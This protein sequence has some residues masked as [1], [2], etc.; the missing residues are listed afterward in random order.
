MLARLREHGPGPVVVLNPGGSGMVKWWPHAQEAMRLFAAAGVYTVLLG[1][2][3][4]D[5]LEPVEPYAHVVGMEWPVRHALTFAQLA[6]AVVG[7]E[8]LIVNAV[9]MEPMLKVV[10]LSHSSN[11]NLTKHWVNTAG[12]EPKAVGCH[13]CHRVHPQTF[14]FCSQDKTTGFAACQA[15]VGPQMIVDFVINYLRKAG[16]LGAEV[17]RLADRWP[18]KEA[19]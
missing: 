1:R 11:E 10:T 3:C 17:V 2:L 4:Q 6:D 18:Q 16:K 19:A 5:D 9:A 8:S 7:T 14:G 12:I 13:P 15:A